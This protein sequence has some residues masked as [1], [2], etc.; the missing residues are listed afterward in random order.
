MKKADLEKLYQLTGEIQDIERQLRDIEKSESVLVGDSVRDYRS[1]KG[2]PIKIQ[3]FGMSDKA[4]NKQQGLKTKLKTK[5]DILIE[6][7]MAIEDE[8]ERVQEVVIRRIIRLR[9]FDRLSWEAVA[10]AVD[11][12]KTGE[13]M[14]KRMERYL[15]NI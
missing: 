13:A 8:L 9:Y 5:R 7:K 10:I 14:R 3:G 4:Y 6:Q 12:T 15:E 1:G 11:G 2:V